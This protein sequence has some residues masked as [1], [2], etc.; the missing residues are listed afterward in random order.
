MRRVWVVAAALLAPGVARAE[1][2]VRAVE[3]RI[4]LQARAAPLSEVLDQLARQTGMKVVY[5]GAPPRQPITTTIERRTPVEALLS[6]LEGLGLN[7]AATLDNSGTHVQM[8]VM[9]G[10]ATTGGRAAPPPVTPFR[11]GAQPIVE[12]PEVTPDDEEVIEEPEE[13][14]QEAQPNGGGPTGLPPG[15]PIQSDP[16]RGQVP[17]PPPVF[18]GGTFPGGTAPSPFNPTPSPFN[19]NPTG[20]IVPGQ[21]I[22]GQIVPGQG[23]PGQ[24]PGQ[25]VPNVEASPNPQ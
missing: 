19:P 23:M 9:S 10:A 1:V 7:Y 4:D 12:Q 2:Q 22:P 11:G 20:Q 15:V 17:P 18:P 6:V 21:V 8:L 24:F 5:E 25:P 14:P 3:G 16:G 13:I